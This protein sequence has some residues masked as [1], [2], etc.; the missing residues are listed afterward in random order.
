MNSLFIQAVVG[1]RVYL[2]EREAWGTVFLVAEFKGIGVLIPKLEPTGAISFETE[3]FEFD[4][5]SMEGTGTLLWCEPQDV[6]SG[7]NTAEKGG[8]Y[9]KLANK[10][11]YR[12]MN[13]TEEVM[14]ARGYK[15]LGG[16]YFVTQ[17]ISRGVIAQLSQ[18]RDAHV[19]FTSGM[20]Y[21]VEQEYIREGRV[22]SLTERGY[23]AALQHHRA[24][25]GSK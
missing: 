6:S 8:Q 25:F 18:A 24:I 10:A 4:G 19:C 3:M 17:S 21:S 23:A 1:D 7:K 5:K 11:K 15:G 14:R 16:Y 2:P 13:I 12:V 20:Q 22:Y 9:V